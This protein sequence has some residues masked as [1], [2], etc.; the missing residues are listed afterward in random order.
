[1]FTGVY[2]FQHGLLVN[3]ARLDPRIFTAAQAFKS[4]G[5]KTAGF[6]A[7][8]F[9]EDRFGFD[10]SGDED[11]LKDVVLSGKRRAQID[12]RLYR[13]A[14]QQ[15]ERVV[16]WL[17]GIKSSD[18]FFVWIH[19]Y[20][21]HQWST[22]TLLP[23]E[24]PG[25][26]DVMEHGEFFKFLM[27]RHGL[28]A[29]ALEDK[30]GLLRMMN[31][32]DGRLLFVDEQLRHLYEWMQAQGFNQDSIWIITSDHGEGLRNHDYDGHGE[33]IYREQ[34][35]VPLVMH[36]PGASAGE[37][38]D[39]LVRTVDLFPTLLALA[40]Y[41]LSEAM[42]AHTQAFSL[43]LFERRE[44]P[45]P[46][47]VTYAFAQRRPKDYKGFR[48]AWEEGD[49]YALQNRS[50][51]YIYHSEGEDEFFNL[52]EDP[53]ELRNLAGG[54]PR[55]LQAAMLKQLMKMIQELPRVYGDYESPP[56]NPETIEDL[57]TL[58]YM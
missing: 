2:P 9:L 43:T 13:P 49:M 10:P 21:V 14:D 18:K 8:R 29:K 33:K 41:P 7:V 19:F 25:K 23:K 39:E 1:M 20:D 5:Y 38:F 28:S 37:V 57:Q 58:G 4:Q 24:Y 35:H 16:K 15:V 12:R 6:S 36:R 26:V 17:R 34:L 50:Y 3:G 32:Y 40:D 46:W 31:N 11:L 45:V 54:Q 53:F 56:P 27:E 48:A 42:R 44:R 51:K 47:P 52:K 55:D 22:E 30:E